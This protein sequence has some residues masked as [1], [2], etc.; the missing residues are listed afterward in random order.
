M[1][2]PTVTKFKPINARH[3]TVCLILTVFPL[4]L[5]TCS[6]KNPTGDDTGPDPFEL[7][8]NAS[9]ILMENISILDSSMVMVSGP[10]ESGT[11]LIENDIEENQPAS[12]TIPENS[13][14]NLVFIIDDE[15]NSMLPHPH[16][17]GWINPDDGTFHLENSD[18]PVTIHRPGKVPEPFEVVEHFLNNGVD[19]FYLEGE[20]GISLQDISAKPRISSEDIAKLHTQK[21]ARTKIK[22]ALVMDGGD[23]SRWT[24]DPDS[25]IGWSYNSGVIAKELAENNADAMQNWLTGYNFNVSRTSQYWGNN[26]PYLFD[27]NDFYEL[28]S[29]YG[30]HFTN[31]GP[32]DWGCDEFFLYI[33]SHAFG[34]ALEFYAPDGSGNRFYPTYDE[35]YERLKEFPPYVKVTIFFDGCYTGNAISKYKDGKIKELC[36]HLCALTILTSTDDKN[37]AIAP[38][39]AWNSGTEDFMQGASSDLDGDGTP[40]DIQD[41]FLYMKDENSLI[42]PTNPQFYHC[43]DG[44]SWC[45]TDG[46]VGDED[47]DTFTDADDNCPAVSNQDQTDTDGDGVGD[48]CDNCPQVSNP[49]QA[50]SNQNGTGDAC[51][52]QNVP[53]LGEL[54]GSWNF[55]YRYTENTCSDQT[56]EFDVGAELVI[57]DETKRLIDLI[58]ENAPE[59]ELGGMVRE[60]GSF[61][62]ETDMVDVSGGAGTHFG[63]E[64]YDGL[65][66]RGDVVIKQKRPDHGIFFFGTSLFDVTDA[67]GEHYCKIE[68]E[69]EGEKTGK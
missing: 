16:R 36:S 24:R 18:Y 61:S 62:G 25:Y 68:Y 46:P 66:A 49:G 20:G 7:V 15:P 59:H 67:E 14:N 42:K 8:K 33:T 53:S 55:N 2:F 12:V 30:R 6:D 5:V 1:N 56:G 48:A 28:I 51:E 9:E 63:K 39:V 26:H 52:E 38:G 4:F 69:V 60:D 17:F 29:A 27:T 57:V 23:M 11:S 19:F 21:A 41:R 40:G 50:D 13:G 31:L 44:T 34:T 47:G 22:E 37:S 45:S 3:G 43:P 64:Y 35:I 32:P 54:M 10:V 58:F 65:F